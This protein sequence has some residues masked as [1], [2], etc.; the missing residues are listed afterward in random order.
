MEEVSDLL[1]GFPFPSDKF[2]EK[3]IPLIRGKNVKRGVLDKSVNNLEYWKNSNGYEKFLLAPKDILLQ[4][5]GALIGKSYA[6]VNDKDIP[7]LL[8][9]RVTRVRNK[10]DFDNDFIYQSIQK[11]FLR[12]IQTIKT[13]SAV[14]HLSLNDI[15]KYKIYIA[16]FSEQKAIGELFYSIDQ[17]ITLHQRESKL[18][19]EE[20]II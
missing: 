20:V 1:T 4:M 12:Y 6:M 8:V 10:F 14:P 11:D 3:G 13:D 18:N 5:D 7:A 2:V 19:F 17:T 16:E 15:K 9:Q